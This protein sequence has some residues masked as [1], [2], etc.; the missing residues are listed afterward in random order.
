[1]QSHPFYHDHKEILKRRAECQYGIL[2]RCQLERERERGGGNSSQ[3][4]REGSTAWRE[5][6][7]HTGIQNTHSVP[8]M[9]GAT[10]R[11]GMFHSLSRL[12]VLPPTEQNYAALRA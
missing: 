2:S 6:H 7:R 4:A 8:L 1:M 3:Q 5:T 12:K 10:V 9:D 11:A